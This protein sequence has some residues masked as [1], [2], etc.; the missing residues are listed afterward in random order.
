MSLTA[1]SGPFGKRPAG[2]FNFTPDAPGAAIYWEPVVPRVRAIVAG[3][4]V[5]DSTHAHLLHETGHLPV[6]CFP[7]GD[8][9]GDLLVRSST[10]THCPFKGEASYHSIH[11]GDRVVTDAIWEYREPIAPVAFVAGSL[12]LYWE[13]ADAWLVEESPA[14]AHPRDPYHR[15]DV[16]ETK[17][18]VRVLLDVNAVPTAEARSCSWRQVTR[19]AGTC[20][21]RTCKRA[22]SSRARRR[23]AARTKV[24]RRTS[25]R[26]ATKTSRGRM[27]TRCTTG[28]RCA[29]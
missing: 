22:C 14:F 15:I 12:A 3:E 23:R 27:P 9:R 11:V 10:K 4:T 29:A 16:Y 1:G 24:R 26:R 18:H 2:R 7:R 21:R 5:A 28:S 20:R 25:T 6:Y 13:K 19:P 8:V 17:R